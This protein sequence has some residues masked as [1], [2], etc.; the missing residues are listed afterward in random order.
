MQFSP[1]QDRALIAIKRWFDTPAESRSQTFRV[2]GYAGTG[3]TTIAKYAVEGIDGDVYFAA[4]TGKAAHVLATKG[5]PNASTLHKLMYTPKDKSQDRLEK[6]E[7]ELKSLTASLH[8]A[9]E[10]SRASLRTRIATVERDIRTERANLTR[11]SFKLN[12]ESPL[13]TAALLVVDEYYMLDERMVEDAKSFGCPI[14]AL[15]DPG[16]LEPVGG[17]PG[18]TGRPDIMLTDIHR[19][20]KESPIIW[21]AT[22]VRE[23]RELPIGRFGNCG[24]YDEGSLTK[25]QFRGH[26]L[27]ASQ[28]L[29]GKNVTRHQFNSRIRQLRGRTSPMPEADERVICLR[30]N[31]DLGLLNGQIWTTIEAAT[32][33][34]ADSVSLALIDDDGKRIDT[35][36]HTAPF[37]GQDVPMHMRR[38]AEEFAYGYA[39]TVHKSQ[40][41]QWNSI[42]IYDEWRRDD[43]RKWMYT[44]ITR[45][46]ERVVVVV[47]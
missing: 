20:A 27:D 39:I 11:P 17:K 16:Q 6:L 44:A 24:I 25:E 5:C 14:L 29:V 23:G 2:D 7:T 47:P 4:F 41:S 8:S 32:A 28:L 38:D 15:G 45:A 21:L 37:L 33:V 36:A 3:K 18:F 40:G 10:A 22:E 43:W 31:Q 9:P 42:L 46:E 13:K 30:N 35:C 1:E 26:V 12:T 19:Q 34:D